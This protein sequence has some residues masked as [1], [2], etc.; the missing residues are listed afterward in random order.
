MKTVVLGLFDDHAQA[1]GVLAQLAGSPLDLETI[2]VVSHDLEM[3][4]KLISEYGLDR[5][6]RGVG[7]AV[8][9]C[10]MLGAV[11]GYIVGSGLLASLGPLLTVSGGILLGAMGGLALGL[12]S[13]TVRV[14]A[15]H[16]AAVLDALSEGATAIVVRTSNVPT[17][18]AIGDLFRAGGSR[19]LDQPVTEPSAD[20]RSTPSGIRNDSPSPFSPTESISPAAVVDSPETISPTESTRSTDSISPSES[21]SPTVPEREEDALFAPPWRRGEGGD[22]DTDEGD[23]FEPDLLASPVAPAVTYDPP[24]VARFRAPSAAE[25]P[26]PSTAP[27]L[28]DD[29]DIVA[30]DLT[31]RFARSLREAGIDT[32]GALAARFGGDGESLKGIGGI[33]PVAIAEFAERLATLAGYRSGPGEPKGVED[34]R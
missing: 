25:A 22:G 6:R 5:G 16:T 18:R 19:V 3:Q 10:A 31:P 30:L 26:P 27:A 12:L 7:P 21:I 8:G 33:G 1:G 17:A 11:G 9:L 4:R 29:A 23:A 32:V 13:E 14:P 2:E 24:A 20:D 15:A 28:S 34:G